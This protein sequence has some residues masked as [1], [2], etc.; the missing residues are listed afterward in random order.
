MVLITLETILNEKVQVITFARWSYFGYEKKWF[1]IRNKNYGIRFLSALANP[2]KNDPAR[3][4]GWKLLL[5]TVRMMCVHHNKNSYI[6]MQ[7]R[8]QDLVAGR[9]KNQ[10]GDHI[11]KIRYWI[12]TATGGPPIS[13]GGSGH[14]CSSRWR[15]TCC[16]G[17]PGT[18]HHTAWQQFD[19][20]KLL[21]FIVTA[22]WRSSPRNTIW[23]Q[24]TQGSWA[25]HT[26]TITGRIRK[27]GAT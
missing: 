25:I 4:P 27:R 6:V 20:W 12:Y 16:N 13:N 3:P 19:R 9:C 7:A 14:H 22:A 10:K 26:C 24:A 1:H 11:L 23:L 21:L 8:R 15:Q 2:K 18:T 17:I 5:Y